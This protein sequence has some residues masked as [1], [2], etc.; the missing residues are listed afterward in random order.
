MGKIA[1]FSPVM[2]FSQI[3][4]PLYNDLHSSVHCFRSEVAAPFGGDLFY[5]LS[6]CQVRV[7][8]VC[9]RTWLL[10]HQ[11][12]PVSV[13]Q[14]ILPCRS[15]LRDSRNHPFFRDMETQTINASDVPAARL[16]S[17]VFLIH[18]RSKNHLSKGVSIADHVGR[19]GNL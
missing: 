17:H 14:S 18:A 4:I 8:T 10:Q 1:D 9:G 16:I 6:Q 13:P 15:S 7:D 2:Q 19:R 11:P 12:Q 3:R 5:L